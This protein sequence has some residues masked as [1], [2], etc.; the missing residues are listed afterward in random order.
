MTIKR[1]IWQPLETYFGGVA[2]TIGLNIHL[3]RVCFTFGTP[4]NTDE[5]PEM[6]SKCI[7][8]VQHHP[9]ER[10]NLSCHLM[11]PKFYDPRFSR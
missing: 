5:W 3:A 1:V 11:K 9:S 10:D 4:Q 6:E 2:V 7:S 8:P